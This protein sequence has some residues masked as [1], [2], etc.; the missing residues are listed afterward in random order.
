MKKCLVVGGSGFI[1]RNL[2]LALAKSEYDVSGFSNVA[3]PDDFQRQF[4][5]RLGDFCDADAIAAAVDGIDVVFHLVSTSVPGTAQ[6]DIAADID[7]N[8]KASVQFMDICHR[9]KV[10]KVVFISSGG[11]VYGPDVSVPTAEDAPTN[12]ISAYGVAKL[13]IEKYF[14]MYAH[15]QGLKSSVVRLSNPYGPNQD[16][17]K[18]QGVI[19]IFLRRILNEE[20]IAIWGD[21]AIVRDYIH[22]DDV[23]EALLR[24]AAEDTLF[25][26]YNVGSGVGHSLME[27]VNQIAS[28]CG[29]APII[30]FM[31]PRDFD[32]P[33]NVLDIGKIRRA[34]GWEPR[35][36][37]EEGI[38]RTFRALKEDPAA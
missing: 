34:L 30:R 28:V 17:K 25:S 20:E 12:P 10:G 8:I 31:P 3:P 19:P 14:Y 36:S 6:A 37:L 27:I 2:V 11:T 38:G 13:S 7:N 32:V 9:R 5:W 23:N 33:E 29:K 24:V 1:G 4:A 35:I 16:A 15:T 26:L 22:I 21:G 18:A